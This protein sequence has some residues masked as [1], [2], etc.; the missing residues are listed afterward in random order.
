M[1]DHAGWP[2]VEG[3][4]LDQVFYAWPPQKV[5]ESED[6]ARDGLVDSLSVVAVLEVLIEA[7]GHEEA[8]SV[9]TADDFRNLAAIRALYE[10]L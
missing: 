9:S 2:E 8:L 7:L 5:R 1:S 10:R 4:L 3:Q 6:L